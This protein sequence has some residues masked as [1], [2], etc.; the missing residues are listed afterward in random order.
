MYHKKI[1][2]LFFVVANMGHAN[3]LPAKKSMCPSLGS[4]KSSYTKKAAYS[5]F[6]QKSKANG[7]IKTKTVSG[8]YKPSNGYKFVNPYSK[9]R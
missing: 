6:G 1:F 3:L 7:K 8:Y 2:T 5:G 4:K 9:S